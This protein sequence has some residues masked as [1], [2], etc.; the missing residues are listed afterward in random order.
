MKF[1][2]R[3]KPCYLTGT[4]LSVL[5]AKSKLFM[6]RDKDFMYFMLLGGAV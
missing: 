5:V 4:I 3:L 2:K 1:S 6:G